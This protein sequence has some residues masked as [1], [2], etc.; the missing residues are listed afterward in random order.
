MGRF[1]SYCLVVSM[2]GGLQTK[3]DT[4]SATTNP[5]TKKSIQYIKTILF[6]EFLLSD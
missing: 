2:H 4:K 3:C 6:A 5:K 1:V